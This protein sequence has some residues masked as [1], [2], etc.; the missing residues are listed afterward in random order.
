MGMQALLL[1]RRHV[2]RI[3][4]Q[5]P[6]HPAPPRLNL[7]PIPCSRL[8]FSGTF[9][10]FGASRLVIILYH[11]SSDIPD[12]QLLS[13]KPGNVAGCTILVDAPCHSGR[14]VGQVNCA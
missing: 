9:L 3:Y 6:G 13:T 7:F 5:L 2:P 14:G 1:A 4:I 11:K 8:R 12:P 10:G